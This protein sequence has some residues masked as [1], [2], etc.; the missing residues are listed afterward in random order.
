MTTARSPGRHDQ[1]VYVVDDDVGVRTAMARV[2]EKFGYDVHQFSGAA[3]FL[4]R[5]VIFRPAVVL[6]DMRMPHITGIELQARLI[7]RGLDAPIIFISGESTAAQS[8]VAL[9]QGAMDFL[10]KPF[11]FGE[12]LSVVAAGIDKDTA[13]IQ[14]EARRKDCLNQLAQLKP[15]ELEAFYHLSKGYSY[16]ELMQAMDISMPT[17]KQY[18][19]AV[20]RKLKFDTLAQLI[21]FH[22]ELAGSS[23][24]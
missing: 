10:S 4:E 20:M 3:D 11:D 7:G 8:V 24:S 14:R 21:Q 17:A 13:L 19:A 2:L 1:H 18:R 12:L 9:K 6:V 5:A 15:R 22:K 16:Q 23:E